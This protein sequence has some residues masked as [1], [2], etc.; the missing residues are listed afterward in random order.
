METLQLDIVYSKK[1][2]LDLVKNE[3]IKVQHI[4]TNTD[5]LERLI[6]KSL[7]EYLSKDEEN[8]K[9]KRYLK[10]IIAMKVN[11][12]KKKYGKQHRTIVI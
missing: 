6:F 9:H 5:K 10:R 12:A 1:W 7:V 11:E 2:L 8:A 3:V 4:I